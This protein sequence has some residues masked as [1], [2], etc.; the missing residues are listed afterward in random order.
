MVVVNGIG[1]VSAFGVTPEKFRDALLAGRSA[2][3]PVTAFDIA[4]CRTQRAASIHGFDA[5]A[6]IAPMKLRRMDD[7]SRYAVV[8]TRQVLDDSA[9]PVEAGGDDGVGVVLGTFTA[10][11]APTSDYLRALHQGGAAAAPALLFN[12][13]VGNAPASLAGLEHKLRGP[14]IT[15]SQ[16]EASG[17]GAIVTATDML[18]SGRANA[19][20]AGGVDAIFEMFFRVHDTFHVMAAESSVSA[21]F[22]RA[23][24]GFLLG[25]GGFAVLL[26]AG[27]ARLAE[28]GKHGEIL[29]V[30]AGSAAV[31]INAWPPDPTPI[32]R[33]MRAALTDAAVSPSEI[34]V[35]YA[36]ANGAPT[37]DRVEAAAI[38]QV[39]EPSRPVVTSIKGGLGEC[40]A[41]GAAATV[42][43]FVCGRANLV[44]PIAGFDAALAGA[45]GLNLAVSPVPPGSPL[46]LVNS[47][48]SGGALFSVVLRV[49]A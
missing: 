30:A 8:I 38:R 29:G 9:Y 28:S 4:A 17:L 7:T 27:S 11:G 31:A 32:A 12:S 23:S 43:A 5:T 24:E 34:G 42:A 14:N 36:S 21:P 44:P 16:K 1:L 20:V 2:V 22:D 3:S 19:L 46:A 45:E 10:G 47:V 40:A 37:L 18:R 13:T 15:V 41:S 6:W 39:F 35:V 48:G 33:T 26:E 49:S 25:E